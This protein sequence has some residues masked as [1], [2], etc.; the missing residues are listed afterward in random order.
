MTTSNIKI[1]FDLKFASL[2][3]MNMPMKVLG[4]V[5]FM[6]CGPNNHHSV[7]TLQ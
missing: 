2:V 4:I 5:R 3:F 7:D 1:S 6:F